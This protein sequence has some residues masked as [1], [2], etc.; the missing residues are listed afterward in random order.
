[1]VLEKEKSKACARGS[2]GIAVSV[3]GKAPQ[4]AKTDRIP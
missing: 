4:G 2:D 1:M 3:H